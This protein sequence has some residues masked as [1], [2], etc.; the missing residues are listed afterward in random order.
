M[1]VHIIKTVAFDLYEIV[2]FATTTKTVPNKIKASIETHLQAT[3]NVLF[4]NK[5]VW[6]KLINE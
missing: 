3:H 6:F 4:L 5:S 2:F 1:A